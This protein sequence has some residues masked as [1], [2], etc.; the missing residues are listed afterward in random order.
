MR[1]STSTATDQLFFHDG[2]AEAAVGQPASGVF[3]GR[4]RADH[5]HIV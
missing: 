1:P 5:H 2:G 4:A 3:T